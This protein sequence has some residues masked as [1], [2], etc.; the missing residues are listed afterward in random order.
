MRYRLKDIFPGRRPQAPVLEISRDTYLSVLAAT[1]VLP[2]LDRIVHKDG[3]DGAVRG[4]G[5]PL[6]EGATKDDLSSPLERGVYALSTIDQKTVL[7]LRVVSKEEAGFD[8][9]AVAENAS[10][11]GIAEETAAKIRATWSLLQVTVESYDPRTYPALDFFLQVA[12]RA[13]LLTQGVVADPLAH[14]YLDPATFPTATGPDRP[15]HVTDHVSIGSRRKDAGTSVYT[16]GLLK[17]SRPE[18]E[19]TGLSDASVGTAA[20][21]LTSLASTVMEGKSLD[22]GDRLIDSEE[23][24]QVAVGGLDRGQWDGVP[25]LELIPVRTGGLGAAL[26]KWRSDHVTD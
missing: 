24:L 21:F 26:D 7:K 1:A 13:A 3:Q 22:P 18:I 2:P 23:G 10:R 8:P 14:R 16:Q 4:L 19:I 20:L 5:V 15:F 9:E 12:A 17:F 6:R 11:L 25:C